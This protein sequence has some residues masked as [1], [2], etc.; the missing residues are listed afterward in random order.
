MQP[1]CKLSPMRRGHPQLTVSRPGDRSP[2]VQVEDVFLL[3]EHARIGGI[4]GKCPSENYERKL[5]DPPTFEEV[6][7]AIHK[8][9]K[10]K[11]PGSD[12]LPAEI[13]KIDLFSV[14][15]EKCVV[16]NEFRDSVIIR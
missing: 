7:T 12:G 2:Q 9:K 3:P 1:C 10:H 16:P 4:A 13:F 15:W 14:C 11:A 6:E 8:L 5:D